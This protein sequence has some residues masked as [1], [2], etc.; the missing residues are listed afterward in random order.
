MRLLLA[1]GVICFHTAVTS[2]G[3]DAQTR[4]Q[5][6]LWWEPFGLI[7]PMFFALSGFLVAGSLERCKTLFM[8]LGLRAIRI[9]PALAVEIFISALIL[10]PLFT[11]ESTRAYFSAPEFHDYFLNILG[12]I[13]YHLPGVFTSNPNDAVNGQ[14][15]TV[16][17]ELICYIVI[18]GLALVGAVRDRRKLLAALAMFYVLQIGHT[19]IHPRHFNGLA[20]GWSLVMM[21]LAGI[22]LYRYRDTVPWNQKLALVSLALGLVL[23]AVP[24]GDRFEALPL[25]YVTVYLGLLNPRRHRLLLSGDYSYG[26]FLYGF[27]IQ[28]ACV[29]LG[30][31]RGSWYFN[32]AAA[33]PATFAVAV[34]SWWLI[35]KPTLKSRALLKLIEAEYLA[36]FVKAPKQAVHADEAEEAPSTS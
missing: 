4:L 19:I 18:A 20:T 27:P 10:G 34:I 33:I 29:A 14:L 26:L 36:R 30:F 25:A 3:A 5:Y 6:S 1:I 31:A 15:W 35:E 32:L 24:N 21:F 7:L 2:Y 12:D 22:T 13:H 9:L 17:Y 28:Q 16:P 8:F 23:I 11:T